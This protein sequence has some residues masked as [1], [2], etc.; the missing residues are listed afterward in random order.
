LLQLLRRN[1][2]VNGIS[3]NQGSMLDLKSMHSRTLQEFLQVLDYF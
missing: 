3:L 2:E 1:V